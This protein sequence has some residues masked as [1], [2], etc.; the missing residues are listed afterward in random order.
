MIEFF[1]TGIILGLSAGIAPGA[2]LALVISE[3]IQ[4]NIKSGIK[5]ALSP[6]ASDLPIILSALFVISKLST[7]KPI[8][9]IISILGSFLLLYLGIVNIRMKN[10]QMELK[11]TK[12]K[13]FLKGMIVN[14]TNPNPYLFWLVIGGPIIIKAYSVNALSLLS[15]MLPFYILLFG[16]QILIAI[17]VGRSKSFLNDKI[18]LYSIRALGLV[19]V[20]FAGILFYD[21][22]ELLTK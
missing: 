19:L 12:P 16:S 1:I 18:Y 10:I 17:L 4:H 7:Y 11:D 14:L 6:L 15:F 2:L 21:G 13:S 9:G 5:V 22:V 20:I 8:L 3:T